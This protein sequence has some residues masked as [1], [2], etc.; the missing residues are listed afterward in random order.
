MRFKAIGFLC[1]AISAIS[2]ATAIAASSYTEGMYRKAIREEITSPLYLL[3]TLHD[4]KTGKDRVVCTL[5]SFLLGAIHFEQHLDFDDASRK[6]VIE[7]ALS[8]PH[9]FTFHNPKAL[10]NIEP[11]YSETTVAAFRTRLS[12]FSRSQLAAGLEGYEFDKLYRTGPVSR[13]DGQQ[14]AMAR[15]LLER[16]ILVGQA[17]R[18]GALFRDRLFYW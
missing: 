15:A 7:I 9:R 5:G 17:D 16:G 10:K 14:A 1:A 12:K 3:F 2:A 11:H 13:W 18:T 8:R 4:S 6:K